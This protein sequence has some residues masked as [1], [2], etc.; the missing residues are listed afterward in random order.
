VV[1][2][3]LLYGHHI[4]KIRYTFSN[5]TTLH[6]AHQVIIYK[7]TDLKDGKSSK[8][9]NFHKNVGHSC[10]LEGWFFEV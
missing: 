9:S 4:E 7:T 3:Y 1:A 2:M 5:P 8:P 10:A 6:K